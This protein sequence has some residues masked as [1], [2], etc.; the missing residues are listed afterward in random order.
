MK[1]VV[2]DMKHMLRISG[3]LN[4]PGE[5]LKIEF[6]GRP[7]EI[8]QMKS[9]EREKKTQSNPLPIELF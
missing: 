5:F 6:G 8:T 2:Y 3:R 7:E 4:I 9:R 1:T